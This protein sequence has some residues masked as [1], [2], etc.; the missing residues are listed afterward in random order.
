MTV[1]TGLKFLT[2]MFFGTSEMSELS[3]GKNR[4]T[5]PDH[6]STRRMITHTL[7]RKITQWPAAGFGMS[8][9]GIEG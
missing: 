8:A 7:Y 2:L 5:L 3:V 4:Y 1:I 9:L 6:E